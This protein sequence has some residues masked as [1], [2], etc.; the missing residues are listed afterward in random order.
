[1]CV[2]LLVFLKNHIH[3]INAR[4]MEHTSTERVYQIDAVELHLLYTIAFLQ[5]DVL[6]CDIILCDMSF[7]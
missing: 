6:S 5:C 2:N 3:V 4:D 7:T 1:M